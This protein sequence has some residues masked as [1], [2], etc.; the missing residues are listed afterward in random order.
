MTDRNAEHPTG[1]LPRDAAGKLVTVADEN[2]PL[3]NPSAWVGPLLPIGNLKLSGPSKQKVPLTL[4][5]LHALVGPARVA[6]YGARG[7]A[8]GNYIE[9]PLDTAL[10]AYDSGRLRHHIACT[11]LNGVVTA[12][13]YAALDEESDLP[14]IDHEI[15]NLLI[16]RT[17][18]I[19]DGVLP[20]DPGYGN[21]PPKR[22]TMTLANLG[23]DTPDNPRVWKIPPSDPDAERRAAV[24]DEIKQRAVEAKA[25]TEA[26]EQ[27]DREV[28]QNAGR[29]RAEGMKW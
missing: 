12:Q 9:Q 29:V 28:A 18:M 27:R 3:Q 15:M 24:E 8:P 11:P 4:L 19:R 23:E 21:E 14:H 5:P 2:Y 6:A 17:L 1:P 26:K 13:S 7:Y 10:A 16:L 22:V 20:E 25:L